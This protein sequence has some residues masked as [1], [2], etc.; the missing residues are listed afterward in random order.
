MTR[1]T[2]KPLGRRRRMGQDKAARPSGSLSKLAPY[3]ALAWMFMAIIALESAL[4]RQL[5]DAMSALTVS[6]EAVTF[7]GFIRLWGERFGALALFALFQLGCLVLGR[8]IVTTLSARNGPRVTSLYSLPVGW[9]AMGLIM[10]AISLSGIAFKGV[11]GVAALTPGFIGLRSFITEVRHWRY[12]GPR[13]SA[14]RWAILA[15]GTVMLL[16]TIA[17][18]AP[19][20]EVDALTYHYGNPLRI[21]ALHRQIEWPFSI[22]DDFPPLWEILLL[23]LLSLGGEVATRWFNPFIAC[24]MAFQLYGLARKVMDQRWA[25]AAAVLLVTNPFVAGS[26]GTAKNDLFSA[27]MALAAAGWVLAGPAG[28]V[29]SSCAVAGIL[30]GGAF[31]A[32]YNSGLMLAAIMAALAIMGRM[33]SGRFAVLAAG[34]TV[35]VIPVLLRNGLMTGNPLYPFISGI[36]PNPYSSPTSRMQMYTSAYVVTLQDPGAVSRWLSLKAAFGL[37]GRGEECFLRWMAFIPFAFLV[38]WR[39]PLARA[40]LAILVILM[41]GWMVGPPQVRYAMTAFPVAILVGVYGLGGLRIRRFPRAAGWIISCAILLQ[42]VHACSNTKVCQSV[43]AGLGWEDAEG[44]RLRMLGSYET[45]VRAVNRM[46][47]PGARLLSHG[48]CRT[49]PLVPHSTVGLF[50][51]SVFPPFEILQASRTTQEV[52]KKFRQQGWTSFLYN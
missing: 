1:T 26:L 21:I 49:A 30:C 33:T 15:G 38:R 20:V 43:R 4:P 25:L 32:K 35:A 10:Y 50:G 39:A 6:V 41:A 34:F 28:R 11:L 9:L 18:L 42:V 8:G 12:A 44:Y 23:P 7:M 40:I 24:F 31:T 2:V 37:G 36:F 27:T 3:L 14:G 52:W 48:E 5:R 17:A 45:A 51:R 13:D 22:A 19:E 47:E 16:V 46:V 29:T